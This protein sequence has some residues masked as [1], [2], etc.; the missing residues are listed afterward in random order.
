MECIIDG[1][2]ELM[3]GGACAAAVGLLRAPLGGA[4]GKGRTGEVDISKDTRTLGR[5]GI[6]LPVVSM[7]VMNTFFGDLV[8]RS[9]EMGARHFDTATYYQWGNNEVMV[10]KAL[11]ELG[12]RDQGRLGIHDLRSAGDRPRGR[13][14]PGVHRRGESLPRGPRRQ[15]CP[16]GILRSV[17]AVR[18]HFFPRG[19][20]PGA[21]EGPHL[22]GLL[23]ERE[24]AWGHSARHPIRTRSRDL[25]LLH[26]V[27]G[28]MRA[29]SGHREAHRGPENP[30]GMMNG[31]LPGFVCSCGPGVQ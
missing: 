10:S 23:R 17:R 3:K 11:A 12:V 20:Y 26:S 21:H 9:Y 27:S 5:T 1:R 31:R 14:K 8:K 6:S 16:P 19:R 15:A 4:A 29:R 28:G 25:P 24:R 18:R 22:R 2:K 30:P 7:G 13:Q